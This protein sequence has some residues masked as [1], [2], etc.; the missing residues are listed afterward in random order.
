MA[1][2]LL[3]AAL[4]FAGLMY[5]AETVGTA[6]SQRGMSYAPAFRGEFSGPGAMMNAHDG[7]AFGSLAL[8]PLLSRPTEWIGGSKEMAYRAARPLLGWLVMLTSLGS[9]TSAG[10]G[11]L[12]WTAIGIGLMAAGAFLLANQWGRQGDWVPLLLLLPGVLGQ[13]LFGGLSDGLATGLALLGLAWWLERRDRWAIIALCL[14]A[15][16]RE[17]TLLVPLALLLATERRR[18]VRLVLPFA[19]YAG[20][21]GV[22]WLRIGALPIDSRRGRLALPPGN[23]TAAM[24]SWTWVEVLGA[25]TI[26]VLVTVAWRRA[27]GPEVRWLVVLSA[28]FA[29][30]MGPAVL[31]AWDF[32]RPLLPVTVVG[33]CLLARKAADVS[34]GQPPQPLRTWADVEPALL[35]GDTD[36]GSDPGTAKVS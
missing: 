3:T 12:A 20:W 9:T 28:L 18:A 31:R 2:G 34:S 11:L 27:P 25:V 10:W 30:T 29:A 1:A 19:V 26:A 17:T 36:A 5:R 22:V 24:R 13:V 32:G 15:L 21:V 7:Q 35:A 23:I 14:A 16:G 8:D 33:A 6:A 4:A